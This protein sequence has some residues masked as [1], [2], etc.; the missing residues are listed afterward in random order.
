MSAAEESTAPAD[1]RSEAS[2][3]AGRPREWE[4]RQIRIIA[5]QASAVVV[6]QRG[7]LRIIRREPV[8]RTGDAGK[9]YP[10]L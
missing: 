6:V 2:N 9:A 5:E 7:G 3:M 1:T 10:F 8:E 4:S